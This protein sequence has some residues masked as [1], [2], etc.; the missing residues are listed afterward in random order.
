MPSSGDA[1]CRLVSITRSGQR[2]F[3]EGQAAR[4]SW[5]TSAVEREVS[6]DELPT[7]LA[8]LALL[9]RIAER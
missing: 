6:A 2:A 7:L 5:L 8:G 3:E 4:K 9:R 1:R